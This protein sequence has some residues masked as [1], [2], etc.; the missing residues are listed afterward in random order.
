[1]KKLFKTEDDSQANHGKENSFSVKGESEL[2]KSGFS[3][4]M[5]GS[6]AEDPKTDKKSN[7]NT[8]SKLESEFDESQSAVKDK[9][10]TKSK[11]A[12]KDGAE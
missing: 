10:E 9:T 1:M 7:L 2:G 8:P 3:D 12:E 11:F 6:N 5:K 4:R